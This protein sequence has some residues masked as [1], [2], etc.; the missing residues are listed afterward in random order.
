MR[1]ILQGVFLG[2]FAAPAA[3][4]AQPAPVGSFQEAV[5]AAWDHAPERQAIEGRRGE[6]TARAG[7]AR[8]FFPNAPF[9]T[10]TYV[11][12]QVGSGQRYITYQAQVGTPLWLPGEG[13]ATEKVA[14]ADLNRVDADFSSAHLSLAVIVLDLALQATTAT[15][16][17][18]IAHHRLLAAQS[19]AA[20]LAQG[21]RA[22]EATR[23]DLQAAQADAETAEASLADAQAQRLRAQTAFTVLTGMEAVPRIMGHATIGMSAPVVVAEQLVENHPRVVAA[24]RSVEAALAAQR[25]TRIAERDSPE[26]TVI[27]VHEKQGFATPYNTR[28]GVELRIP[29]AT[30]ARNAPRLALARSTLMNAESN[31]L[32]ARRQTAIEV[33]QAEIDLAA[34]H[35]SAAASARAAIQ[36][37]RRRVQIERAWRLGEMPL[38]EVVRARTADFDAQLVRDRTRVLSG[39]AEVRLSLAEGHL[40]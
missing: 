25:L 27:G 39:A 38:I 8:A 9:A 7:A 17:T 29:F 24:Q 14:R 35:L 21:L 28:F 18:D 40:P 23:S 12:D 4:H 32:L 19:L 6:A 1:L 16:S 26:V 20:S 22:G 10:G 5:Q 30:Q 15:L 31:L 11:N 37:Q 33:R 2:A 3:A 36:L 34:T 13:T